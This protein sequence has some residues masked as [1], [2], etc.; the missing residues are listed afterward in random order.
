MCAFGGP[1]LQT[2]FVTTIGHDPA[3]RRLSDNP[4][5]GCLYAFRSDVGGVADRPFSFLTRSSRAHARLHAGVVV[6]HDP[7]ARPD[8]TVTS[9]E[10]L[11]AHMSSS[12]T[13]VFVVLTISNGETGVGEATHRGNHP[14]VLSCIEK[15]KE[16]VLGTPCSS[17]L[18]NLAA[19]QSWRDG[20]PMAAAL[21]S[22]EQAYWDLLGKRAG[23]PVWM[24]LGGARQDRITS[25][26]NIN[27]AV[28]DRRLSTWREKAGLALSMG[29]TGI[30]VAPFDR[31]DWRDRDSSRR[32]VDRA[33][34]VVAAVRDVAG[35][36]VVLMVD[37]HWRFN[38]PMAMEVIDRL[39]AYDVFWIEGVIP[40]RPDTFPDLAKLRLYASERN[41]LL[42]G[43]EYLSGIH[44]HTLALEKGAFDVI[45]PDI[46]YC[47]GPG[48]LLRLG[49]MANEKG[50]AFSP[51][52]PDGP[53]MDAA[54]AHVC[55]AVPSVLM[56]ERQ[57]VEDDWPSYLS[58]PQ[59]TRRASDVSVLSHT[60]GLGIGLER[61]T[62]LQS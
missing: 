2:L 10:P 22:F 44:E 45:N 8:P 55:H 43:G 34:D 56:L 29:F 46:R 6:T 23:M 21:S 61:S 40:E 19:V 47:G 18:R 41:I 26:S 1:D 58:L 49:H 51:H 30:K 7:I 25:Y 39:A 4:D 9:V 16:I 5:E 57:L 32:G 20:L 3:T 60:P 11:V 35:P 27:R 48:N 52:N 59:G 13:F 37:C 14:A 53:I 33:C 54:T 42:A 12:T 28:N 62:S 38:L 36:D 31:V 15:V 50:I 24:L 17:L